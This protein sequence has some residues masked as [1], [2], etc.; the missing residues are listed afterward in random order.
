M[1]EVKN[2]L[3]RKKKRLRV[4]KDYPFFD[5]DC[6]TFMA[7]NGPAYALITYSHDLCAWLLIYFVDETFSI[8]RFN[9]DGTNVSDFVYE[10]GLCDLERVN[11]TSQLKK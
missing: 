8:P 5:S 11:I 4:H 10:V 2:N 9:E 6:V 1:T 3:P 7:D